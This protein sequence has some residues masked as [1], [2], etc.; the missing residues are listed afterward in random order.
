MYQRTHS[1]IL[2]VI[3]V[4]GHIFVYLGGAAF[5]LINGVRLDAQFLELI[6]SASPALALSGGIALS[7]LMDSGGGGR[8]GRRLNRTYSLVTLAIPLL[9]LLAVFS[10][11]WMYSIQSNFAGPGDLQRALIATE[12]VFGGYLGTIMKS[13]FSSEGK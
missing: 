1:H 13:L 7:W 4:F 9:L 12:I 5:C 2:V 3:C 8:S 11:L 10:I 6:S